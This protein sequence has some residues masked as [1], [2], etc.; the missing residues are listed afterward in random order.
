MAQITT[1]TIKMATTW[2]RDLS[3]KKERKQ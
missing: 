2:Q 1:T 3:L